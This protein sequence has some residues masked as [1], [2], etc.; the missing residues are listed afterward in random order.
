MMFLFFL[1]IRR[2]PR[3]TRTDTL[4]PYTTLF[5]SAPAG[6]RAPEPGDRGQ[7]DIAR[8]ERPHLQMADRPS[9]RARFP[10]LR[11]AGEP[12]FPVLRRALRPRLSGAAPAPRSPP[13]AAASLRRPT[14][15]L[16]HANCARSPR[17]EIG[18]AHV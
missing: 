7:D 5:R 6:A 2:P 10:F 11:P 4:F 14:L 16:N 8:S 17:P 13:A 15:A 3:S 18:R 9:R 1:M 12:R